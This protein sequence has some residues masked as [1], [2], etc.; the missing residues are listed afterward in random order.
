MT[1]T[2]DDHEPPLGH[3]LVLSVQANLSIIVSC[4]HRRRM[5]NG[6]PNTCE[7]LLEGW[8]IPN[9]DV[10]NDQSVPSVRL[11]VLEHSIGAVEG[12][13]V[14]VV[15]FGIKLTVGIENLGHVVL[16]SCVGVY[17]VGIDGHVSEPSVIGVVGGD[18]DKSGK[19]HSTDTL[20]C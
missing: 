9:V 13:T 5:P 12:R 18:D 16:C 2:V 1:H 14:F 11:T 8:P 10:Y 4:V 19:G 17:S 20:Q 6:F 3:L 15:L 7:P